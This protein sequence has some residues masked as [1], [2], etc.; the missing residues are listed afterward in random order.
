MSSFAAYAA[1]ISFNVNA[2]ESNPFKDI[3]GDKW[4]SADVLKANE[5]GIMKGVSDNLFAPELPMTR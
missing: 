2:S 1:D 4:Y 3:S 5:L